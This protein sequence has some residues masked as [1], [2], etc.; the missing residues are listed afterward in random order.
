[1]SFDYHYNIL[2]RKQSTHAELLPS[3]ICDKVSFICYDE[4]SYILHSFFQQNLATTRRERYID[5][6]NNAIRN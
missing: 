1:M 6:L 2:Y 3:R 4:V 5:V